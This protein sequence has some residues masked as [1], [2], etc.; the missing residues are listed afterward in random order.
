[1]GA[2]L[3]PAVREPQDRVLRR[4]LERHQL[5]R[6]RRPPRPRPWHGVV[7]DRAPF[8]RLI[9]VGVDGSDG[10]RHATEWASQLASITAATVLAVHVLTYN[11]ELMRDIT[12]DTV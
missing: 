3:L 9:V 7:T 12:P 6:R 4:H 5:V 8:L 11:H 10:T 1:M 2:R